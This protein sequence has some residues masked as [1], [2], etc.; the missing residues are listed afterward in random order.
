MNK[1]N[2]PP[3][4]AKLFASSRAP[5]SP[6]P[7]RPVYSLPTAATTS[8]AAAP[9]GVTQGVAP[10]FAG[11]RK[12]YADGGM[13]TPQGPMTGQPP[14]QAPGVQTTPQSIPSDQLQAELQQFVQSNPQVIQ[15]VREALEEALASGAV[16]QQELDM[17]VQM[18]VAAAQN[19]ELYP[20]LRQMAIQKG[21]AGE[22]DIP[23][24][25]D[26]GIVFALMVAGAALSSGEGQAP[27]A[28]QAA[29]A[30]VNMSQ[31]GLIPPVAS[32]TGD[33]TGRADDVPINASAGEYVV[34]ADTV[35]RKGTDFFDKLTGKDKE[36]GIA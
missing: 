21:L 13:V 29:A 34:D 11:F 26:Q 5:A 33:N 10:S 28:P 7:S 23:E 12:G 18:A 24:A 32:P 8:Y 4:L 15:K 31:G 16:T 2:T 35:R 14:A 1:P 9:A 27:A 6:A 3:G 17:A 19:P 30:P 20:R 25:Y 22:A 36:Q